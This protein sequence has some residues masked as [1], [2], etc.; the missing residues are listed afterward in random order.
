MKRTDY[1]LDRSTSFTVSE[2]GGTWGPGYPLKNEI[3]S[4]DLG[5]SIRVEPVF[6]EQ[7]RI[8]TGQAPIPLLTFWQGCGDVYDDLGDVIGHAQIELGGYE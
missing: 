8:P 1:L 5:V 4:A 3:K 6:E 7:R 2:Y